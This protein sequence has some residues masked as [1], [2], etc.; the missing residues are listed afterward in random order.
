M[1]QSDSIAKIRQASQEAAS[2]VGFWT[3]VDAGSDETYEN[4]V[5]GTDITAMDRVL[6][7]NSI[8]NQTALRQWFVLHQ[9]YFLSDLSLA[10]NYWDSYLAASMMR[11]PYEFAQCVDDALGAAYGIDPTYVFP[12]GTLPNDGADPATSGMHRF[13][14]LTG[15]AGAP[16]WALDDGDL[17]TDEV[18]AAGVLINNDA[19]DPGETDVVMTCTLQ[20]GTTKDLDVTLGATTLHKQ[21]ILGLQDVGAAGA[22]AGQKVIPVAATGQFKAGEFVFIRH[23]GSTLQEIAEIDSV[24]NNTSLTVKTNLLNSYVQ[25]DDVIPLF[26]DVAYKSGTLTNGKVLSFY[27]LPDRQITL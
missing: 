3:K 8:W 26:S 16:T 20:D 12:K 22:A 15:T 23:P 11:V 14:T 17:D 2:G 9:S 25:N 13:G 21:T 4:R 7:A 5:K 1:G 27:A 10:A 6:A 24:Q 19:A 18:M